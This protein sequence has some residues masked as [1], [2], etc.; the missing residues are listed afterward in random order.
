[1]R[2]SA[3]LCV[4]SV[5]S[6]GGF[7]QVGCSSSSSSGGTDAGSDAS[8]A[9]GSSTDAADAAHAPY[10]AGDTDSGPILNPPP[11]PGGGVGW[12]SVVGADGFFGQT[13]DDR[14]WAGRVV[15]VRSLFSVTCWG[16][17]RG[18]ISGHNG[19]VARTDDGG[20]T[21]APEDAHLAGDLLAIRFGSPTLG[22]V[23]GQSGA[24]AITRDG[25][26]HWL[27]TAS[28]TNVT[29]RGAAVAGD[30]GV[31]I[32]VGDGGTILRSAD[33]GGTWAP[34][35]APGAGDLRAVASDSGAHVV[36]AVDALGSIWS[37]ADLGLSFARE[38][39]APAALDAVALS[40]DG[41]SA[42]AVGRGGAALAR[43]AAGTWTRLATGTSSDLHAALASG[44]RFYA[45]GDLGTLVTSSD[46]GLTWAKTPLATTATLYALED[47]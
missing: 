27:P 10:D 7:F 28:G 36:L 45:A 13:F 38:A 21:W 35:R 14:T 6:V 18:W 42:L 9:G 20:Q 15:G 22:V 44:A 29:L 33:S 24:L 16:N 12:R 37:S 11:P 5:A 26:V 43:D 30:V 8:D 41:S 3:L 39:L 2:T 40:D 1:M 25:G 47:L 4:A 31:M 46:Q 34:A 19:L 17:L 23:A 32:V